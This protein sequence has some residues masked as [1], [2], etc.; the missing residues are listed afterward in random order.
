[1]VFSAVVW[2]YILELCLNYYAYFEKHCRDNNM[3][4]KTFYFDN[5]KESEYHYRFRDAI[6]NSN[7]V[8]DFWIE[9]EEIEDYEFEIYDAEEA[10]IKFREL[11]QPEVD[12]SIENKCW[13]YLITYYLN[14]LGYEIKEFPKILARPPVNPSDFVYRDIR[15]RIIALGGDDNGTVRYATRRK[16][17][18]EL[19]FE[20]KSS[21]IEVGESINQKFIE[22]SNRHATFIK[23]T[24]DEKLAEIANLIENFLK[25][26]G[27]FLSLDYSKVCC[28]FIDNELV[29]EY[30]KRMQCFRHSSN[31]SIEERKNYSEEQKNFLI[32]YGLTI[33]KAIHSLLQ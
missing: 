26:D 27:K 31:E 5:I 17:V 23:M 11:C 20:Q 32:D 28:G 30:R 29:K 2:N 12:F 1:M 3:D 6:K 13:F 24:T 18:A 9:Q 8:Y 21:Y 14:T 7:I 10:I 25:N 15:A 22:I 4:L 19:T 16:F 33:V